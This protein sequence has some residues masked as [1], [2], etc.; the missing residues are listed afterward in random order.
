MTLKE[1]VIATIAQT[2]FV[3]NRPY[4]VYLSFN[5]GEIE[6]LIITQA[7]EGKGTHHSIK[8]ENGR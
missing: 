1:I 7:H 5:W 4:E 8:F 3:P 6:F 2:K